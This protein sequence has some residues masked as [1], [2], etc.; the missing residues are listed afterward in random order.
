[1]NRVTVQKLHTLTG[2]NDC[3]YTIAASDQ[4][5][6]FF[7]GAGDGMVV[8]W[9]LREPEQG[10]LIAKLPNSVYGLHY[11]H[12]S[13]LLVA[14]HNYE[15]IHVLDW[16]KKK[17]VASLQMTKAAIFD[18]KSFGDLLF[19]GGGDGILTLM[20]LSDLKVVKKIKATDQSVRAIAIST[21]RGEF[22]VG[23]SDHF[24][25]VFDLTSFEEK[26]AWEAHENSV[27][28]LRYSP[29][30]QLLLSG[31]RDARLKWWDAMGGY[32]PVHEVIAHM[33]TINNIDFSPDGQHFVTCSMDKSIKV[34]DA[35]A[36][37]LLKVI[38]KGRHAGHGTSVN[39]LLW[40]SYNDQLVSASDDRT[41]S[42]W[43]I[44]FNP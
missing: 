29:D 43:K 33:Y 37:K 32:T 5:E 21:A 12:P 26:Y 9:D 3:I 41:L 31:S 39:K 19:V 38:D 30:E 13:R 44:E 28:T 17:E 1:M 18:I 4:P 15:G 8:S 22:A 25:R 2:H 11:H 35:S 10:A 7:S 40:S 23:Y 34:W 6:I 16:K 14:G 42:V 24:I 27:F 36:F 20:R